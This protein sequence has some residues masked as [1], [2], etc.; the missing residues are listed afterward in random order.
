MFISDVV[1]SLLIS[2]TKTWELAL[3]RFSGELSM[4]L[5]AVIASFINAQT[6]RLYGPPSDLARQSVAA[7]PSIGNTYCFVP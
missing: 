3:A 2:S 1:A 5:V 7:G 4:A 6:D